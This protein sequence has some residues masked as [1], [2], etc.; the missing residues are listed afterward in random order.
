VLSNVVGNAVVHGAPDRTVEVGWR[1]EGDAVVVEVANEGP[2]IPANELQ[3]IFDPFH[4]ATRG[5]G[6]AGLGLG[7][8]IARAIVAAHGGRIDVRSAEG[9]RT[10]FTIRLP[11][12][13]PIN[14]RAG[15]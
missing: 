10:V 5:G 7:L 13:G 12:A 11:R 4:R 6:P 2:P 9:E 15:T 8:F 3:T 1:G 14:G